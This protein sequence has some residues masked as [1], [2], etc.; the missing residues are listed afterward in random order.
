MIGIETSRRCRMNL[1]KKK[2]NKVKE[3]TDF[4][5]HLALNSDTTSQATRT[6]NL[7]EAKWEDDRLNYRIES[8]LTD[9]MK[10]R[11]KIIQKYGI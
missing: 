4:L 6:A 2:E 3:L 11:L 7:V 5:H 10:A 8:K 9:Q 1:S